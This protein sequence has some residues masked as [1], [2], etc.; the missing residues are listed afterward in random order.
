MLKKRLFHS[1]NIGTTLSKEDTLEDTY[2]MAGDKVLQSKAKV[3]RYK[4]W[5]IIFC[6]VEQYPVT[7]G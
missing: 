4:S 7:D 5:P 2:P 1:R 6:T 3:T